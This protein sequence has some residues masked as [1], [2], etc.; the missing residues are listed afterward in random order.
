MSKRSAQR[1]GGRSTQRSLGS[2]PD[3]QRP[4]KRAQRKPGSKSAY[5]SASLK[6]AALAPFPPPSRFAAHLAQAARQRVEAIVYTAPDVDRLR[7]YDALLLQ[8][9]ATR[10][11]RAAAMFLEYCPCHQALVAL[12][13]AGEASLTASGKG[14]GGSMS[15][16]CDR[17]LAASSINL[18]TSALRLALTNPEGLL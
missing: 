16:V 18:A 13:H 9:H 6:A 7:S 12:R 14:V 5:S 3:R 17:R 15:R 4:K 10:I 2:A 8:A 1:R 11:L